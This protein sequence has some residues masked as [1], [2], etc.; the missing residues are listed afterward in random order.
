MF[1]VDVRE[2]AVRAEPHDH[3]L[4]NAGQ[5]PGGGVVT[6]AA[7][8]DLREGEGAPAALAPVA[9]AEGCRRS[10]RRRANPRGRSAGQPSASPREI[11]RLGLSIIASVL[12]VT[13]TFAGCARATPSAA[14]SSSA[15]EGVSLWRV[16]YEYHSASDTRAILDWSYVSGVTSFE[17]RFDDGQW[18]P[19]GSAPATEYTVEGEFEPGEQHCFTVRAVGGDGSRV[20][21]RLCAPAP[22]FPAPLNLQV[23]REAI[24]DSE[25]YR[26]TA[27]WDA[28]DGATSYHGEVEFYEDGDWYGWG[29]GYGN[30]F[31]TTRT[32]FSWDNYPTQNAHAYSFRVHVR[33]RKLDKGWYTPWA[34]Y[35]LPNHQ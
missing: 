12:V 19:A 25:G 4:G 13:L 11:S 30:G 35:R 23:R 1:G 6:G 18:L 8:Q 16:Q 28:V 32:T 24:P 34:Y 9:R 5:R 14:Y 3:A 29:L 17:Y 15:P 2:A 31:A 27:T 33:A 10:R 22:T 7:E 20:S 21:N 26:L